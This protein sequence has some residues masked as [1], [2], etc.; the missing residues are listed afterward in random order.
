MWF[1]KNAYVFKVSGGQSCL[2]ETSDGFRDVRKGRMH[3]LNFEQ[4][5]FFFAT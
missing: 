3:P 1:L 4:Q 2:M 5:L